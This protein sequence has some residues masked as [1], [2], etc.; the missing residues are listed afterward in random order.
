MS[1]FTHRETPILTDEELYFL[2]ESTPFAEGSGLTDFL[3]EAAKVVK[4]VDSAQVTIL[5]E[6]ARMLLLMRGL[7]F[8][9]VLRGGEAYRNTLKDDDI[10]EDLS[11]DELSVSCTELFAE[12]LEDL[13]VE[14]IG[15]V[16]AALGF[17][18]DLLGPDGLN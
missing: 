7:Y 10:L 18:N 4:V 2:S 14:E 11:P 17:K 16:C 12:D 8:L 5:D 6:R 3:E 15:Q 13:T 9:G 1:Y